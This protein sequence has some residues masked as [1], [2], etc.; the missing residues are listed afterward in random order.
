MLR[1][2]SIAYLIGSLETG[3]A[4]G[5]VMELVQRLDR[6]RFAPRL[7]LFEP[8]TSLRVFGLVEDV[9]TLDIPREPV[10]AYRPRGYAALKAFL[11]LCRYL[12]RTRPDILHAH[13]PASCILGLPAGRLCRI[14]VVMGSR[15]SLTGSYRAADWTY[16]LSDRLIT[17][18][19]RFMV[20][21]AEAVTRELVEI[22]GLP[23]AK[24]ATIYNGVDTERF[25]P[26]RSDF[27]REHYGWKNGEVVFGMV[28]NFFSNKRHIDFVD[29]AAILRRQYPHTRFVMAGKDR[30]VMPAVRAAIARNGLSEVIQVV[31]GTSRP[32]NLYAAMDVLVCCSDREGF[33]NVILEAMACGKP[34]I[35]TAVGGNVEAVE[36]GSTGF[37]VPRRSPPSLAQAAECLVQDLALRQLMGRNARQRAEER[38]SVLKMVCAHEQLYAR[39]L[40]QCCH[41]S[42]RSGETSCSEYATSHPAADSSISWAP[43]SRIEGASARGGEHQRP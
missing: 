19:S 26:G 8:S 22:D 15:R 20:G 18:F 21:N 43:D 11:R 28:A 4:E 2:A 13:L 40:E 16:N 39:L 31:P 32:E 25:R 12:R 1:P 30:G 24:T 42:G 23:A 3:G 38:F 33:S 5:Q 34:V 14:P 6:T 36:D 10:T 17:R 7:I 9:F 29:A 41:W 27:W 37:L 35:A